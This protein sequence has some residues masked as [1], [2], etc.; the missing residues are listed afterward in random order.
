MEESVFKRR[1]PKVT[2]PD[3]HG[4]KI[5][6]LVKKVSQL[7]KALNTQRVEHNKTIKKLK[8]LDDRVRVNENKI[9]FIN[10]TITTM[11]QTVSK[12]AGIFR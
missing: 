8:Y 10:N 11:K 12:L 3:D 7:E 4:A 6:E 2:S 1:T 9:N 5:F